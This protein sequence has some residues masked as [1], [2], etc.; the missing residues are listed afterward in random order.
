MFNHWDDAFISFHFIELYGFGSY[1]TSLMHQKNAGFELKTI[2]LFHRKSI[3]KDS[4]P[5]IA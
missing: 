3:I 2:E 1:C 4:Q 5:E